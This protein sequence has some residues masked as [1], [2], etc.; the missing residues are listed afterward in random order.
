VAGDDAGPVEGETEDPTSVASSEEKKVE[1]AAEA[2][3]VA[4]Q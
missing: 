1:T 2:P 3:A 4:Q